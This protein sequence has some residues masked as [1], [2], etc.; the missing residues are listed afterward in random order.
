MPF[1]FASHRGEAFNAAWYLRKTGLGCCMQRGSEGTRRHVLV[2]ES[3]QLYDR[4]DGVA[5]DWIERRLHVRKRNV[6]KGDGGHACCDIGH[7]SGH[8]LELAPAQHGYEPR[9]LVF[10]PALE[11]AVSQAPDERTGVHTRHS[12][13]KPH[14][15]GWDAPLQPVV[16]PT[17]D[18]S[19]IKQI[20]SV[21]VPE[22]KPVDAER[23]ETKSL[24][25]ADPRIVQLV[26]SGPEHDVGPV[27]A[28]EG[29]ERRIDPSPE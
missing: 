5:V 22:P 2:Y 8:L 1:T 29:V 27:N 9:L 20:D 28:G 25:L 24:E 12:G 7:A 11:H 23:E 6:D 16:L 21:F 10:P 19:I 14:R 18:Y 13:G 17:R 3:A 15:S 26:V 4:G